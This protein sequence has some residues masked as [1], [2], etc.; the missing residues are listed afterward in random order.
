MANDKLTNL[1]VSL[2]D[3]TVDDFAIV[4]EF[5]QPF[6]EDESLLPRSEAELLMLLRHSFIAELQNA[7]ATEIVGFAAVEIYSRKL[8]EV[9]CLAVHRDQQGKGIGRKLVQKCL[10]R[11]RR[12]NVL[13]LMA[14][15]ASDTFLMQCGFDYSLPNQKRALFARPLE[16]TDSAENQPPLP[17]N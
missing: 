12:E 10:E 16:Q 11:A 5:L 15:S 13:E 6:V 7:G 2:R 3:A 4:A 1:A 14:I 17:P 8:A 9:Q